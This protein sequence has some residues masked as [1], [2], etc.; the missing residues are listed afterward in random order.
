MSRHETQFKAQAPFSAAHEAARKMGALSPALRD[1]RYGAARLRLRTR[2]QIT[3]RVIG[4]PFG[5]RPATLIDLTVEAERRYATQREMGLAGRHHVFDQN[6]LLGLGAVV[7]ELRR[8]VIA[9]GARAVL[10]EARA[11]REAEEA[12]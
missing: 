3:D 4:S 7:V 11:R 5:K 2:D 1:I 9:I 6:R 12:E 10:V 8:R